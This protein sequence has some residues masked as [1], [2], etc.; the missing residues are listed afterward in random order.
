MSNAHNDV[1]IQNQILNTLREAKDVSEDTVGLV[2]Q[3]LVEYHHYQQLLPILREEVAAA[4]KDTSTA[5]DFIKMQLRDGD[6]V[7]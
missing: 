4:K 6:G 1:G 7:S 2:E 5:I 3:I